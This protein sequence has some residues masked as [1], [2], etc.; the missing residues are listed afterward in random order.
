MEGASGS[1]APSTTPATWWLYLLACVDGRTYAGIAL[2][3]QARFDLHVAGKGAKFTRA[4][5]PLKILGAQAFTDR[6]TAQRAECALKQLNKADKLRW[7]QQH[8]ITETER[9]A[10]PIPVRQPRLSRP[11][12]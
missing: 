7:A 3:L 1:S 10:R 5:P 4:N 9:N 2:D 12:T 8:S 11:K 6:G